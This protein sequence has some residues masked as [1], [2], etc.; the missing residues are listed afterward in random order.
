MGLMRQTPR[1]L[2]VA[3]QVSLRKLLLSSHLMLFPWKTY[4]NISSER[5]VS[6]VDTC[7]P[8]TTVIS[9]IKDPEAGA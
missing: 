5:T 2:T 9:N 6:A 8:L 1:V 3:G 7:P 4:P